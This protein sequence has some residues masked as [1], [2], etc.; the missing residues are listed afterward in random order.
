MK[1]PVAY[2]LNGRRRFLLVQDGETISVGR[3]ETCS[4]RLTGEAAQEVELTAQFVNGCQFLVVHPANGSV[5]YAQPLPWKVTLAGV[6][7]QLQRPFRADQGKAGREL[8]LQGLSAGETR[9]VLP[10][11]KPLLLGASDAC[12]VVIPD[13]GCPD[14]LLA[15]W[16][17]GNKVLVQVLDESAVVGWV[18]RAGENE[19]ELELPVSLSIG[20]R[21]LLFRSGE[22]AAMTHPLAKPMVP[23]AAA[24]HAPSILAKNAEYAPKII[25]R[26]GSPSGSEE[27]GIHLVKKAEQ[28]P[29]TTGRPLVLPPP[30]VLS[31][32]EVVPIMTME[33][34]VHSH[35]KP[36]TP[37][38]FILASWLQVGLIFAV[39]L[40]PQRGLMTPEQ[41]LQLWYAA[42]GMLILTLVLGLGVLL[43]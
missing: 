3:G 42:G 32:D 14:V 29:A 21:V 9:L 28:A 11:D 10:T 15:L 17:A 1:I 7:L 33:A 19:A 31:A 40:L 35:P 4:I 5:P 39:A 8:I 26:Q 12:D 37:K 30:S 23:V 27:G 25:A 16:G 2:E 6:E 20:G 43:K 41:I 24:P 13:A 38:V 18:G 22:A 34:A 36:Y